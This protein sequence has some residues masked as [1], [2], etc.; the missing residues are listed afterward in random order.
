MNIND[1]KN[2]KSLNLIWN[3]QRLINFIKI[4]RLKW[5]SHVA[6][7]DDKE[8]TKQLLNSNP[9]GQ[10]GR[11]RPKLRW[12]DSV[13]HDLRKIGCKN[14]KMVA[15]DRRRWQ[16][17]LKE[18]SS[19]WALSASDDDDDE[20]LLKNWGRRLI[21]ISGSLILSK[22]LMELMFNP[23]G[24]FRW[25]PEGPVSQ[26][27]SP[28][29]PRWCP[30]DLSDLLRSVQMLKRNWGVESNGKQPHLLNS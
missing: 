10:W 18:A 1:Y 22:T 16:H 27:H 4:N 19:P 21:G 9:G 20:D 2:I 23:C 5:A 7:M 13:E 11:G 17:L 8:F 14:W 26:I 28:H 12:I 25:S 24:E 29:P 15:Q 3:T 30:W 6:Q